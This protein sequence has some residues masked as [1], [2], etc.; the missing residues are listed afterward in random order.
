MIT[1]MERKVAEDDSALPTKPHV[2]V[3][4]FASRAFC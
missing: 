2:H 1:H 3:V 4:P